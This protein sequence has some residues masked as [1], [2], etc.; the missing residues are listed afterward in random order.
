MFASK[1]EQEAIGRHLIQHEYRLDDLEKDRAHAKLQRPAAPAITIT[2]E[3][4]YR[5]CYVNGRRALWHRWVNTARPQLPKGQEPSENARYFQF[6]N[7]TGLVEYE[8]GTMD[9]VWPRDIQFL[10]HGRFEDYAWPG[11]EKRPCD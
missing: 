2:Q 4:D 11:E 6:R 3:I 8:D 7:T 9:M 10:D 5:P 1:K